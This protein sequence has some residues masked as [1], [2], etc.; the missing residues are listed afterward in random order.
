ML[1]QDWLFALLSSDDAE[2]ERAMERTVPKGI[3]PVYLAT[4]PWM[5]LFRA[6]RSLLDLPTAHQAHEVAAPDA[7]HRD[8]HRL[9]ARVR[10][11]RRGRRGHRPGSTIRRCVSHGLQCV[12][13][14]DQAARAPAVTEPS[15]VAPGRGAPPL[16]VTVRGGDHRGEGGTADVGLGDERETVQRSPEARGSR[17][18]RQHRGVAGGR[19]RTTGQC[20]PRVD[21]G[22]CVDDDNVRTQR[23]EG[24]SVVTSLMANSAMTSTASL[25]SS[26]P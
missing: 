7:V 17:A 1:L 19:R 16:R 23:A 5:G 21:A 22:P 24:S 15:S 20:R 6:S 11:D 25:R 2:R 8:R 14:A 18:R 10:R 13:A 12:E 26:A 4:E 3:D 9:A